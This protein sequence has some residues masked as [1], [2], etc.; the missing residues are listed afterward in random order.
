MSAG[1]SQEQDVSEG[2][3][4]RQLTLAL[5]LGLSTNA[6]LPPL[7]TQFALQGAQIPNQI[8][9]QGLLLWKCAGGAVNRWEGSSLKKPQY[10]HRHTTHTSHTM[11]SNLLAC[12]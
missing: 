11:P 5:G 1:T 12:G 8:E 9:F 6:S 2:K 10:T 3:G 7:C 4:R